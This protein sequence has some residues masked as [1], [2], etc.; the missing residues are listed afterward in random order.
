[1]KKGKIIVA[2]LIAVALVF[3]A[4]YAAKAALVYP[5]SAY[6]VQNW[7]LGKVRAASDNTA[8]DGFRVV[9]YK[10]NPQNGWTDDVVGVTG[11][12]GRA[13]WYYINALEDW[14]IPLVPGQSYYVAVVNS[15][16][17]VPAKGYGADPVKFTLSDKGF[18]LV[19]DDLQLAK[20]AGIKPPPPKP[21]LPHPPEF[22]EIK[23]GNRIYQRYL[24]DKYKETLG[25][26]GR[27]FIVS[28]T[29]KISAKVKSE[30]GIDMSQV[31][32]V[33]NENDPALAKTFQIQSAHVTA[34]SQDSGVVK[35]MSFAYQVAKEDRL[36][37]GDNQITFKA[38]NAAG[39]TL[40]VASVIVKAGPLEVIGT[41]MTFP[42]PFSPT[43]HGNVDI[44]YELSKDANIDIYLIGVG[45]VRIKKWS[46]LAGSEGGSA[47]INKVSWDGVA[48]A[49]Y[50]AG[51]A[52]YVG[53]II[54]RDEGR[55][56]KKFKLTVVN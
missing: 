25:K 53:T 56:L 26:E 3:V 37:E 32:M 1:M 40:E 49:G 9:F 33:L 47:G 21:W 19:T 39:Q 46:L 18:T 38:Q 14:R 41:P 24:V 8:P 16:P 54:S 15:D 34:Q 20:G 48:D 11:I 36:P 22:S 43:K 5:R 4:I 7:I 51:N 35:A 12:S 29:P 55:L 23:F 28:A 6:S 42:S 52:I 27:L 10:A 2:V 17:H 13:G 45:G 30:H 50:Y 31:F 44:Q